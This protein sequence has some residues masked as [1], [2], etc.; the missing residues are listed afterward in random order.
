MHATSNPSATARVQAI[1]ASRRGRQGL[2]WLPV[3]LAWFA[4]ATLAVADKREYPAGRSHAAYADDGRPD[5]NDPQQP[6]PL[7]ATIWYPAQRQSAVQPWQGGVFAFGN[8]A[9]DAQFAGSHGRLPLI[10]VSHGTGGAAA[11]LSWLAEALAAQ[12]FLVAG[13]NHHGNTAAEAEPLIAGFVLWWER[14]RDLGVLLD[15]LLA[16]PRFAERIDPQRIGVAGFS[17]GGY[18][19]LLSAGARVDL[20]AFKAHCSAHADDDGC[21]PP[22]EATHSA[23]AFEQFMAEDPRARESLPAAAGSFRDPRIRAAFVIAPALMPALS[24][25]S[26]RGIDVPVQIVTG[27]ADTLVPPSLVQA[28]A[29]RIAGATVQA[30]ADVGHYTFLAPCTAQGVEHLPALCADAPGVDR[31]AVHRQVAA[32]ALAFFRQQLCPPQNESMPATAAPYMPPE[33]DPCSI[34]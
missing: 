13:V 10:L 26:L 22:P 29:Q 6:R 8:N 4:L 24:E 2:L 25:D 14:A 31:P 9:P 20:D 28:R 1:R 19:A 17:L 16:D 32:Q 34:P 21:R 18:T 33:V 11:Q 15:R 23:Q 12:G 5:W 3:L 27:A 7:A 30:L